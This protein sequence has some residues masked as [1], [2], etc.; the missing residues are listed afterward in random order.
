MGSEDIIPEIEKECISSLLNKGKRLDGRALNEFRE[1]KIETNVIKKAESS[2]RVSFGKTQVLVGI[3]VSAG[4]PYPDRPDAGVIIVNAE[5]TP[6]ASARFESGPPTRFAIEV[7]RV[8]DRGIRHSDI[9]DKTKLCIIEGK[10]VFVI[11][12]DIY[13]LSFDGNLFDASEIALTTALSTLKIPEFEITENSD[14]SKDFKLID[15]WKKIDINDTPVSITVGKLGNVLFIDPDEKEEMSLDSRITYSFNKNNEL[16][17]LQKGLSGE[18]TKDEII[19][20]FDLALSKADMLRTII[21]EN[22]KDI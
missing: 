17:A 16:I 14:G 20:G 12:C 3:K 9:I 7:A 2:A 4:A 1:I 21:H 8:C 19:K 6:L 13:A 22:I 18:F 11:F 15:S 5:L 10:T